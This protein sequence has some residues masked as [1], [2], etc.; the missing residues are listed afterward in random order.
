MK[1]LQKVELLF[2]EIEGVL[3][4]MNPVFSR[5]QQKKLPIQLKEFSEVKELWKQEKS[6]LEVWKSVIT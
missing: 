5:Q 1:V 6:D 4:R 2:L 3:E